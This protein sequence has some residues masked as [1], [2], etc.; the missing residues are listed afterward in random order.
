MADELKKQ[1]IEISYQ[2]QLSHIGSNLCAVGIIDFIYSQKK[3]EDKFVLS[4]GHCHL[5]LQVVLKNRNIINDISLDTHPTR[6]GA[7]DCSSGSLGHGLPIAV[8]MALAGNKVWCL[9]SDGECDE[10]S[11][12]EAAKL[13]GKLKLKNLKVFLNANGTSAYQTTDVHQIERLFR[14]LG[15]EVFSTANRLPET[16]KPMLMIVPTSPYPL[17][18][19]KAHYQVLSKQEYEK[20]VF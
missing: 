10:G 2:N 20:I 18:G 8:G 19:I 7:I 17:E 3:P 16:D 13:A 1:I 12:Y 14:T 4:A 15:W 5:A 11:I 9:I 6:G